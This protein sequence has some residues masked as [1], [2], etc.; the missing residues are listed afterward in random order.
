M[1][2]HGGIVRTEAHNAGMDLA[3]MTAV[4]TGG[5]DGIGAGISERLA[6]EG[7]HPQTGQTSRAR[8][9]S[10]APGLHFAH[11]VTILL[12]SIDRFMGPES[13]QSG[14]VMLM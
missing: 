8:T 9:P 5:A 6:A 14:R 10:G 1:R 11:S 2:R 12:S 4:V 7:M 13:V 3:G